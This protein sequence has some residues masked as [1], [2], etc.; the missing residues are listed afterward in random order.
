[1]K[2]TLTY[3]SLFLTIG[4]FA[5]NI[6]NGDFEN[7]ETRD[8]FKLDGWYSP[9]RNVQRTTDAKVGNY[10]IKLINTYSATSN[11]SKGY[12]RNIDYS[13]RDI[14]NGFAFNGDALSMVFWSKHDLAPGDTA[15]AYVVFR[16]E[17]RYKGRVDFRFSGTTNGQFVKY[18]VPLEWNGSRTPDTAWVYLYSYINS[19][20]N[21]DGYV[22]FD[23]LHFENIGQRS[24]E[25][26]NADFEEWNNVGVDFPSGWRSIDLR[27]YDLYTSFLSGQSVFQ[28]SDSTA[29]QEGTSLLIKN[30][31][32][33]NIAR[34]GYCYFGTQ[35]NDYYTP[36]FAFPDTFKYLQGY[37]KYL[38][39]GPDTARINFRTWAQTSSRSNNNL[40]LTEAEDWTFF[41]MP[42]TYNDSKIPDSAAMIAY[43]SYGDTINGENTA[44]YL[45]KLS[46]V[47]EPTPFNLSVPKNT[48]SAKIFPNPCQ[49]KVFIESRT[50]IKYCSATN[51]IGQHFS[52][53]VVN[54][55]IDVSSLDN[56]LY[57]LTIRDSNG[58]TQNIKIYKATT[59]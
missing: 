29:F 21:G 57:Y 36:A 50:K 7:W 3:I 39:E 38:P 20:V 33:N 42:L 56:G 30:Y 44:L 40:Y 4:L 9:T 5:Q 24:P 53:N 45:D 19:K 35:D 11:G 28:I 48:L 10:A 52:L 14:L 54:N 6:P 12:I 17:G 13:N 22:I 8:H 18:N 1:M 58:L 59:L 27:T 47:M 2:Y 23:D 34:T 15:R 43:S 37:Y 32:S 55:T 31:V 49:D 51:T 16:D 46:M 25:I 41:S 26:T